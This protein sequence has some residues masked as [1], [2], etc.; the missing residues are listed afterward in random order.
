MRKCIVTAVIP[1]I[2]ILLFCAL[3]FPEEGMWMLN[4]LDKLPLAKM[5]AKGLELT[6]EQIYNSNGTSLKDAIVL[7]GGGT[8]SFVSANGLIMTNHHVAFGAIQSVSSVQEDYLKDGFYAKTMEEELSVPSYSAQ[9]L[10]SQKD[11]TPEILGALSDTMSADARQKTIQAKSREIEKKEKG[12]TEFECRVSEFYNGVKYFLFTYD[13]LRDVRLVYAPPTAIGNYGGEVDNWYWPRHT[14]DFSIMRAYVAPDGK[15]ARYDKANVPYNPK[16][17]LPISIKGYQ[18]G[19]FAMIMGYPGRTFRYRT[20]PEIKLAK[21]ETLPLSMELFKM[22]MD[23]I[24]AAGKKDRAVEIKFASRWR[25]LANVYKNYQGTLEGMTRADILKLRADGESKFQ[26]FLKSKPDLRQKYGSVL[27]DIAATYD[28]LKTFNRKQIVISQLMGS[29]DVLTI[30]NRFRSFAGSFSKDSTGRMKPSESSLKDL[31]ESIPS[32]FKNMDLPTDKEVLAAMIIKAAALPEGQ[33][34]AEIQEIARNKTGPEL[35]EKVADFVKDLYKGT[36]LSSPEGCLKMLEKSA[37]DIRDDDFV[38]FAIKLDKDNSEIQTKATAFNAKI[39]RL[40]AKLLEANIAW[41]GTDIYPDANRTMRITYG[42]VKSYNPRDA[43]HYDFE[44][45]LTGVMEKETGQDPF[46]VPRKLRE[47]WS[48]R[49][50]SRYADQRLN[51]VPVAFLANLDI[52][53]G[54]SGSPVINGKGE[55]IGLAFDGNWEAVVGD[56]FF[57]ETLNR[58]INVDARYILFILDKYSGAQNILNELVIR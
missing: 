29:S 3:T 21:E 40:R 34:I 37:D 57:Q 33:K 6:A 53:G 22:R 20:G 5:H 26:E 32:I 17:F 10:L 56:Y 51:D 39:G 30:A 27:S 25:G 7:L 35:E 8:S 47:L 38:K 2:F 15:R 9:L 16:A 14:G 55:L 24:E 54:N 19:S 46:I 43:V 28:E 1:A 42:E 44:T 4:Q 49:D 31:K 45:T 11:I 12:D 13:V 58:S 18:E 41:K 52:T 23:I 48:S 50:F 36:R